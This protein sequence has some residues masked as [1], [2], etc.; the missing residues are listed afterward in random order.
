MQRCFSSWVKD[1][2]IST[3]FCVGVVLTVVQTA[4]AD[5]DCLNSDCTEISGLSFQGEGNSPT[6]NNPG[7]NTSNPSGNPGGNTNNNQGTNN[8]PPPCA[9]PPSGML[10]GLANII[11]IVLNPCG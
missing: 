1:L 5:D 2:S 4:R 3:A 8:N 11:T 7:G 10:G 6:S 9:P